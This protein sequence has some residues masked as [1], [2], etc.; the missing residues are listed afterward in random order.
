[1]P[2]GNALQCEVYFGNVIM[3][4]DIAVEDLVEFSKYVPP[5]HLPAEKNRQYH[6]VLN[7]PEARDCGASASYRHAQEYGMDKAL[8]YPT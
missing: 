3:F 4:C 6:H 8:V 1:M 2:F 5:S 7:D